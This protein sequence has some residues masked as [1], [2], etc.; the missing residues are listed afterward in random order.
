MI[1]SQYE[2]GEVK[3]KSGKDWEKVGG[4]VVERYTEDLYVTIL[5]V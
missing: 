2:W 1:P 3:G 5:Y 4:K